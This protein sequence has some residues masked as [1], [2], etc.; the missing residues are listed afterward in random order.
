METSLSTTLG[1]VF[2]GAIPGAIGM[3]GALALV[4]PFRFLDDAMPTPL[5]PLMVVFYWSIQRPEATPAPL[6]FL[7]GLAQDLLLAGPLGLWAFAYLA[8]HAATL[9][10]RQFFLG[11]NF[12]A[13][14]TGFMMVCLVVLLVG[15]AIASLY[16]GRL[17]SP[18]ELFFQLLVTVLLY[19]VFA[20]FF[21]YVDARLLHES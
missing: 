13:V 10:Q 1:R 14:W 7:V 5:I 2:S 15:W 11:R 17:L 12:A 21:Q 3:A 19:P 6:V 9:S 18:S 4:V 16:Y 8:V 20:R